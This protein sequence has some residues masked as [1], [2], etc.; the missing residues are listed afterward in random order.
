MSLK[1]DAGCLLLGVAVFLRCHSVNLLEVGV[2]YCFVV[3]AYA[4]YDFLNC[5]V[6]GENEIGAIGVAAFFLQTRSVCTACIF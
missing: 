6:S 2:E 5:K 3:H 4:V 1:A